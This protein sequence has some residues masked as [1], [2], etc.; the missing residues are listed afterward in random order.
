MSEKDLSAESA[1]KF[2]ARLVLLRHELPDPADSHW[3]LLVQSGPTLQSWR[4]STLPEAEQE[5]P[6]TKIQ[7]HRLEY[8]EYEGAV[9][10]G[11]GFVVRVAADDF[12]P[13]RVEGRFDRFASCGAKVAGREF[14]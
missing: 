7:D 9:S 11:R 13:S 14:A 8:L 2:A 4:L 12:Y 6:A 3:D 1:S 5:L 10:G